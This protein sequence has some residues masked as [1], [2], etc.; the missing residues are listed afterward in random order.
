MQREY[1]LRVLH[2]FCSFLKEAVLFELWAKFSLCV[3][4]PR[5]LCMG[6]LNRRGAA[7]YPG[8]FA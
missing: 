4:R 2:R 6:R 8:H 3:G 1:T 7:E 5:R